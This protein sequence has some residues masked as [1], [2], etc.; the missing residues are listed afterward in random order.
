MEQDKAERKARDAEQALAERDALIAE[1][2][3]LKK[4]I[5]DNNAELVDCRERTQAGGGGARNQKGEPGPLEEAARSAAVR[6][7]EANQQRD[8]AIVMRQGRPAT[9]RSPWPSEARR[10]CGLN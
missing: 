8:D 10:P 4:T 3:A 6:I 7:E 1:R 9:P 5:T 2:D